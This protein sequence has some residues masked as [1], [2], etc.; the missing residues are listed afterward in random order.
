MRGDTRLDGDDHLSSIGEGRDSD[1]LTITNTSVFS[2]NY[3]MSNLPGAGRVLGNFYSFAGRQ[4]EKT[5]GIVAHKAGLGPAA[6]YKRIRN[7]SCEHWRANENE[8]KPP[9]VP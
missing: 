2:T 4:L 7:L 1:V 6:A 3:T 8:C 5:I 9:R